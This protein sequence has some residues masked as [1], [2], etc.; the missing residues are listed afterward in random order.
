[1]KKLAML[2]VAMFTLSM[3]V[4][5]V[6]IANVPAPPV[7][8][9]IGLNDE[10]YNDMEEAYCLACHQYF[11]SNPDR[12]HMLYGSAMP[13]GVCAATTGLC[14]DNATECANDNGCTSVSGTA[15]C[16]II[17]RECYVEADCTV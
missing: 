12:H 7:N 15:A 8:Q 2:I 4:A 6:S 17:D 3:L 9:Q 16:T 11:G 13:Q 1:M 14:Q 10:V 5:S